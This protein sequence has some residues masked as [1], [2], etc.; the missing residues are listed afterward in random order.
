MMID[1]VK[2][3]TIYNYSDCENCNGK[4]LHFQEHHHIDANLS[5]RETKQIKINVCK[6]WIKAS[7]NVSKKKKHWNATNLIESLKE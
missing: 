7:N 5:K 6:K 4:K 2:I 3:I 1:I